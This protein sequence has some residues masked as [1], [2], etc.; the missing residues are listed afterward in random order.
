M[1]S[2][3][4]FHPSQR[5][6]GGH[7]CLTEDDREL[8]TLLIDFGGGTTSVAI[9]SEGQLRFAGTIR[10]GGLNVTRDIAKMLSISIGEAERMKAIEG[11]VLPAIT[12][13]D[14]LK[15]LPF[16]SQGDN[17]VLSNIVSAGD[18]LTLPGDK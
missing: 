11:S 8:G 5:S 12:S 9:F 4:G 3:T 16:P 14:Q 7:A 18:H 10:M 13:A 17:F 15:S 2:G 6:Y 1:P